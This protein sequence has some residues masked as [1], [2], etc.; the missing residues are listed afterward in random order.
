M[1]LGE[2]NSFSS[3]SILS[4]QKYLFPQYRGKIVL[5]RGGGD[6]FSTEYTPLLYLIDQKLLQNLR[7]MAFKVSLIC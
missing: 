3:F 7:E 6:Y 5:K 4:P 1:L 2:N